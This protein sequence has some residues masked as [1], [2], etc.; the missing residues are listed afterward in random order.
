M[1]MILLISSSL[2]GRS[3]SWL[4]FL[5]RK[6]LAFHPSCAELECRHVLCDLRQN[7]R[8]R[9]GIGLRVRDRVGAFQI[10][11]QSF[12]RRT[13]RRAL[14]HRVLHHFVM[15]AGRFH[16]AAQVRIL[17]DGDALKRRKNHRRYCRQLRFSSSACLIFFSAFFFMPTF[18]LKFRR[19]SALPRV[20][21]RVQAKLPPLVADL[22]L[23]LRSIRTPGPI[24]EVS[25]IFLMYLP[26][27]AAG[28]AFTTA[29]SS[30][31]ALPASLLRRKADLAHRRMDDPGLIQTKLDFTGLDFR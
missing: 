20:P 11:Q 2:L 26:F 15:A 1:N 4:D 5:D 17:L 30:A 6:N 23:P 9:H 3:D 27:A 21:H 25:V 29:A 28:L 18:S 24:V 14:R 31:C 10:L 22:L 12:G 13:F 16:C 19:L 7:F 8:Q